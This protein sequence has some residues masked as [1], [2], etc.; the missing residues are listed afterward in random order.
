MLVI[1]WKKIIATCIAK[2]DKEKMNNSGKS[3]RKDN[4]IKE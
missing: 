3:K 1:N 4:P 2:N